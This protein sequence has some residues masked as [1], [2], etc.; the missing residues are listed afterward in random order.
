MSVREADGKAWLAYQGRPVSEAPL[1][2]WAW[3]DR[4]PEYECRQSAEKPEAGE[5]LGLGLG[6]GPLCF[7]PI[8]MSDEVPDTWNLANQLEAE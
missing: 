1:M 7:A 8:D 4:H 2:F 6:L 5:G 3:L